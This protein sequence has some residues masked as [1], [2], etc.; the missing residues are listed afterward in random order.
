MRERYLPYL[1]IIPA[2]A[3]IASLFVYPVAFN[4]WLMFFDIRGYSAGGFVG[5]QNFFTII[6]SATFQGSLLTTFIYV[7]VALAVELALGL[8]LAMLCN[9]A[10][11]GSGA[12]RTMM[13]LPMMSTPVVVG[14]IFKLMLN[15]ELGVVNVVARSLN[16]PTQLW[17][18]NPNIALFALAL[19]DVWQWT[20]LVTLILLAR[21]K[22]HPADYL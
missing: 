5:L 9:E 22:E 3:M 6:T 21:I 2:I 18:V 20:P 13:I 12:I 8:A 1:L 7:V 14:L 17:L 16:L 19:V 11:R 4:T 15:P 10:T